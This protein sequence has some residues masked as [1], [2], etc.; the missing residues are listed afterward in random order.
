MPA[1][2]DSEQYK[3]WKENISKANKKYYETHDGST[4]GYKATEV[5]KA[6][7]SKRMKGNK[8]RLGLRHTEETKIKMNISAKHKPP[9]SE[10]TKQKIREKRTLQ[11]MIPCSDETK[12]KLREAL[13][14]GELAGKHPK[15]RW[16]ARQKGKASEYQCID[17][18]KKAHDWSN[19]NNHFYR[20]V[21][22]DYEPRCVRCH[23]RYDKQII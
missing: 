22:T 20:K 19:I 16:V 4:K 23:K 5:T 9:M 15:H 6:K 2:K 21:L 10:V 14:K 13:D 12:Q 17:C 11:V 18:G 8:Y 3:L 7:M 1:P